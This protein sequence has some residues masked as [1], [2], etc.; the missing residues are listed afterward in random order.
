MDRSRALLARLFCLALTA[1]LFAAGCGGDE[2]EED[3][4]PEI[5]GS[6][7]RCEEGTISFVG[8]VGGQAVDALYPF[9]SYSFVQLGEPRLDVDFSDASGGMGT[10]HLAWAELVANGATTEVTGELTLPGAAAALTV[11]SGSKLTPTDEDKDYFS[12]ALGGDDHL[13]GCVQN[14]PPPP[15]SP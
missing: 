14:S 15:P 5:P 9:G 8:T 4:D 12:L 7:A 1:G 2:D 10:L 13:D 6:Q 3:R 11:Q